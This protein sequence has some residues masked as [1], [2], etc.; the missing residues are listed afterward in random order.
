MYDL[1]ANDSLKEKLTILSDAAK[2]D[3]ACTS[4]G[5][6]RGGKEGYLGNSVAAG[7][8]HAFSADGR[9][10]SLL[11]I[12]MTNHCIYD[13]KYCKNRVSNDVE[14][15]LFTPEEICTL[16][17]EF[18][19]RNYIEGLFLSSGVYRNPDYT[20][21][22]ICE[23]L[24][25]LRTK[26][27]FNGYIHVKA[28]PGASEELLYSA[29]LLADRISINMELPTEQSLSKLAPN[30]TMKNIIE[31][32]NRISGTIAGHRVAIGKS[33][34]MERCGINKHLVNSIF[35]PEAGRIEGSSN[36]PF[37]YPA[38]RND[39]LL[40]R[41]FAPA[42]QSTQMIIG[43]SNETD[44][45]LIRTT[46]A[47][48]Q[49]FDLKRVFYSAYIPINDDDILPGKDTPV[50][51]L[52]EHRLYQ[53]DWLLRYYGFGA[54]E[55]LTKDNPFLDYRVDPKCSW[56]LNHLDIFPVEINRAPVEMLLRVPGI[57]PTSVKRIISA[58]RYGNVNFEMLKRMHVVLKRAQYFITCNGK[59]LNHTPIEQRFIMGQLTDLEHREVYQIEDS[60]NTGRQMSL[61]SDYNLEMA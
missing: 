3:V 7:V 53:A 52:R 46:Q 42:G 10:I 43:A 44:L 18:Y 27:K 25:L 57:G 47:L 26:Y 36:Q 32:M 1:S 40:R 15:A 41:P 6:S 22:K 23:T 29:G 30:K 58:R 16:T 20:M 28:I 21:E 50:P 17:I 11:K 51:L 37:L 48:Y 55:I 61:F 14:R 5:V 24:R 8:C 39:A 49:S 13:C 56:A 60:L 12:L 2:Y 45:E 19:K 31:P 33:A 9:C 38:E 34:R 59:M 4:S 54:E 35:G